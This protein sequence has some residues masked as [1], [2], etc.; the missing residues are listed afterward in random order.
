MSSIR[1]GRIAGGG[2]GLV[3]LAVA[4]LGAGL[5]A[6][7]GSPVSDLAEVVIAVLPGTWSSEASGPFGSGARIGLLVAVVVVTLLLGVVSGQ[8]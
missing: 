5:I 1:L 7:D 4:E 8:L 2:A 3:G 6:R